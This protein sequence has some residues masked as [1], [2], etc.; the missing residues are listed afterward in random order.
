MARPVSASSSS[1]RP[2]SASEAGLSAD[3]RHRWW[4][5]RRW[6]DGGRNLL[7][8][9]LNPSRADGRRDDPTLRRLIRFGRDWGYD[10]L[11][12]VNLFA[13]M[14]PSPAA[15]LRSQDPI[16]SRCDAELL[17]WTRQWAVTADWDLWCGWGNGGR[18]DQR[19]VQVAALLRPLVAERELRVP[20]RAGPLALGLTGARQPRHPLYAPRTLQLQ[21][22]SWAGI[23]VI[24]HPEKTL[25]AARPR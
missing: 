18:R 5:T 24:R 23:E 20:H 4:L 2:I 25:T 22:F 10:G 21:P 11:V 7:F 15:L 9:G 3:G 13:R 6:G 12:V 19:D 1:A 8:I 14:S 16:G 17:R